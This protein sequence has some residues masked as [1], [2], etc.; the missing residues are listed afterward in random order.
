MASVF[1]AIS[2]LLMGD[3]IGSSPGACAGAPANGRIGATYTSTVAADELI[4]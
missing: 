1:P 2:V 4:L 3:H